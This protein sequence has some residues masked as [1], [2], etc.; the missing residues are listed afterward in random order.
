M[1]VIIDL[2]SGSGSATGIWET[3]G[4]DVWRYDIVAQKP[5]PDTIPLDLFS[6]GS[7]DSIIHH[8]KNVEKNNV[9][10]IWASPP[11]P[12]Y[13]TMNRA[14]N[15][16]WKQGILPDLSLWKNALYII[17]ELQPEYFVIENVAG[18]QRV[19][20]PS[21]QNFGAYHLW[22]RFP[23]FNV[24]EKIPI[25]AISRAGA[26]APGET[27][28]SRA[29]ECAKVPYAISYYLYRAITLQKTLLPPH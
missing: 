27:K 10:L 19:W 18:A 24:P 16:L 14:R 20:G 5:G 8:H 9:L 4:Y 12:E 3:A 22:G 2:F 25:K 23:K 21:R 28:E 1:S 17:Q 11:C 26:W 13:S 29:R 7:C 6:P 15:E